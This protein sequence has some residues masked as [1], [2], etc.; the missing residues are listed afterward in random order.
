MGAIILFTSLLAL[1]SG[2]LALAAN[3]GRKINQFFCLFATMSGVSLY[4]IYGAIEAGTMFAKDGITDPIPWIR[5]NAVFGSFLPALLVLNR[6]AIRFPHL[7][8]CDLLLRCIPW[9]A[10]G[11]IFSLIALTDYFIPE[12]STPYNRKRGPGYFIVSLTNAILYAVILLQTWTQMRQLK[13]IRRLELQFITLPAATGLSL[14]GF[15]SMLGNWSDAYAYKAIALLI[16]SATTVSTFVSICYYR[17][18]DL[19]DVL[20]AS[21]QRVLTILIILLVGAGV[22]AFTRTR[23]PEP[24]SWI[25]AFCTLGLCAP[26]LDKRLRHAF[27]IGG[28][29]RLAE[30]RRSLI[31]C[32]RSEPQIAGLKIRFESFLLAECAASSAVL[33]TEHHDEFRSDTLT[34]S[35]HRKAYEALRNLG[36]ATTET[37]QRRRSSEAINDLKSLLAEH[38]LGLLLAVPKGSPSPSLLVALGTRANEQ[39]Y[40]Y[41]E[42]ERLQNIAELMDNIL[43]H[44]SLSAQAALQAK[45]EHLAM[46]SRG[47]AHDLKNLIT[48][49]SSF[50]IHTDG[51]YAPGSAE[52]EV[53]TAAR[54]SVRVMTDY[55]RDA[56]FFSERLQPKL[57][58]V[59]VPKLFNAVVEL[60]AGRAADHGV[61]V[62][63][64][65]NVPQPVVADVV[66]VQ[67]MLVNLVSNAIDAST[68]GQSVTLSADTCD[69]GFRLKVSDEG[70]GVSAGNLPRIFEPYFTTK[71]FGDDVRG[72]GLGL[73][74]CQK[75]TNLHAG[76]ITLQSEL[77]KGTQV[78]VVLP[79]IP[80]PERIRPGPPCLALP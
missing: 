74:I 32:A 50:L 25:L 40:T 42:I 69:G 16:I 30:M 7:P 15:L 62:R 2:A 21:L 78:T 75:I 19:R 77:G 8:R 79:S 17:I 46:M 44:S 33:A 73:T 53:H 9:F 24:W 49:V 63:S 14:F 71:Q 29:R 34:F 66:L 31:D 45:V 22:F 27:G 72:F 52:A 48:P 56:L 51:Q 38:S 28:E 36:W 76:T 18:F 55:V 39:P 67:R 60:T 20:F 35:K 43:T 41:P 23:L 12:D 13:G 11:L 37:L 70:C 65:I 59:D 68:S 54:R 6:D 5:G 64:R 57:V 58:L 80:G 3:T 26:W 10:L 61:K 1:A 4:C 47:L